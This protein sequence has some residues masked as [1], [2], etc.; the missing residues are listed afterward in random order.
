MYM[1]SR[2]IILLLVFLANSS[3]LYAQIDQISRQVI[4][5]VEEYS[6]VTVYGRALSMRVT[7]SEIEKSSYYEM[8]SVDLII[9]TNHDIELTCEDTTILTHSETPSIQLPCGVVMQY[10]DDE[11][12]DQVQHSG[13]T[14]I[15]HV[16]WPGFPSG[17]EIQVGIERDWKLSDK[18]G[19]YEGE[20]TF[21][22]LP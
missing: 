11:D 3:S 15:L 9:L 5:T 22:I 6:S 21:L 13:T 4:L 20:I 12:V 17:A 7:R 14:Y 16:P 1:I 8:D 10:Y 2:F 19:L 18:A